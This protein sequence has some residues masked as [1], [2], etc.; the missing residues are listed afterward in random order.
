VDS[1]GVKVYAEGEWKVRKHGVGKRRTW[2][3]LHL[4]VDPNTHDVVAVRV[5]TVQVGD[6]ETLPDLLDQLPDEQWLGQVAAD[7]AYD[8]HNCHRSIDSLS[9]CEQPFRLGATPWN[10]RRLILVLKPCA[11]VTR[12]GTTHGRNPSAITGEASPRRPCIGTSS[13]SRLNS[14]SG[15]LIIARSPK[16]MPE[17]RS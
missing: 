13:S 17:L 6:A 10:R 16:P 3:K 2:R 4:A 12:I 7:G 8:D 5:T 11:S 14:G 1:T 15:V 9:R